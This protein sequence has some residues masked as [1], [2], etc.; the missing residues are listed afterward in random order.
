MRHDLA[1]EAEDTERR[2]AGARDAQ[3]RERLARVLAPVPAQ[4]TP[5]RR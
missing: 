4:P 2:R 5:D 1:A 3:R